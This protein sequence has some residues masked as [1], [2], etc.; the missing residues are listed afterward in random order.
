MV[1]GRMETA[2]HVGTTV[3][4][5][6]LYGA[7]LALA[8]LWVA[9]AEAID[10]RVG[11]ALNVN[12]AKLTTD[13]P[14]LGE[15]LKDYR[16]NGFGLV[17]ELRLSGSLSLLTE[18]MLVGKGTRIEASDGTTG[19]VELDYLEVPLFVAVRLR[20]KGTLRPYVFG[21]PTVAV[22]SGA[23]RTLSSGDA[24]GGIDAPVSELGSISRAVRSGELGMAV[25]V[26]VAM[27]FVLTE[28]F[29]EGQYGWGLTDV[30]IDS[31]VI[32][33]DLDDV[34]LKT[35]GFQLR[36]GLTFGL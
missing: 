14:D 20:K 27:P 17:L 15:P 8:L 28:I 13:D 21:G 31:G 18:P 33:Q 7:P 26:G 12:Y 35:R 24:P 3:R 10:L 19:K 4:N 32:W 29:L 6:V 30:T 2:M 16:R 22:K 36:L 34:P 25:G 11:G 5:A 1:S 23:R 9:P